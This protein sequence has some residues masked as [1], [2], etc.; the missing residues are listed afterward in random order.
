[1][2]QNADKMTNH[3]VAEQMA[4]RLQELRVLAARIRELEAL[5]PTG[6]QL[7]RG[8]ALVE[9]EVQNAGHDLERLCSV[10]RVMTV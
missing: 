10:A 4:V 6:S 5:V 3:E 1:M 2:S 7:H 8:I 9:R